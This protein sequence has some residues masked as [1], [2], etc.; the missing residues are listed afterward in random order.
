MTPNDLPQP[1]PPGNRPPPKPQSNE[2]PQP[3]ENRRGGGCWL[4]GAGWAG[5]YIGIT[6]RT[7]FIISMRMSCQTH[8]VTSTQTNEAS[9]AKEMRLSNATV[10]SRLRVSRR[11]PSEHTTTGTP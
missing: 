6:H 8:N 3:A 4:Q 2:S 5:A 10:L 11:T 9:Q 1:Q 7:W